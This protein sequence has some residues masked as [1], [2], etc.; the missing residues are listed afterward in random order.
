MHLG[1]S[2]ACLC[3]KGQ[4]AGGTMNGNGNTAANT[5]DKSALEM[6][7]LQSTQHAHQQPRTYPS[8]GCKTHTISDHRRHRPRRGDGLLRAHAVRLRPA[9][10]NSAASPPHHPTPPQNPCPPP[11][12]LS[13]APHTPS[14]TPCFLVPHVALVA[15][16]LRHGLQVLLR[17]RPP[18]RPG[19][20]SLSLP[21]QL[22]P[23][24]C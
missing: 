20:L 14:T 18:A 10:P 15:L 16:R 6:S 19:P 4:G 9:A 17:S 5:H 23:D 8:P 1:K 7:I 11:Y 13:S 3:S 12:P 2:I 22:G 24:D 21:A